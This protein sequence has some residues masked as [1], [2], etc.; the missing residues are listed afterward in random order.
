MWVPVNWIVEAAL[1]TVQATAAPGVTA[2]SVAGATAGAEATACPSALGAGL[3][4]SPKAAPI[5]TTKATPA[6]RSA[7]R[8]ASVGSGAT[9]C[10]SSP[11]GRTGI[12]CDST[13]S[14]SKNWCFSA[15]PTCRATRTIAPQ[16]S[17]LCA[18]MAI[19]AVARR[20][21]SEACSMK[22]RCGMVNR[23]NQLVATASGVSVTTAQPV[24]T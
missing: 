11:C 20:A 17:L 7:Q 13:P 4:A 23:P 16:A 18:P 9:P 1:S 5:T 19:H 15:A 2:A 6:S 10:A 21:V 8:T 22:G 14:R 3:A 12:M 24:E